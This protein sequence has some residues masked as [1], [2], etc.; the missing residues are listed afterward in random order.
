MSE[1][2]PIETQE[3]FDEAIKSRIDR[4]TKTVTAEI[5]KKYEGYLSPEEV[6]NSTQQYTDQIAQLT[7]SLKGKDKE[8]ADLSAANK[9]NV[10]STA[11]MKIAY[12]LGIPFELSERL[13]GETEDEIR[14][15]AEKI[16]KY[17][18]SNKS[19]PMF[20]AEKGGTNPVQQGLMNALSSLKNT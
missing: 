8:I 2:T 15:D 18:R 17:I 5:T 11:K 6:Q 13:S 1:F 4:N 16:A 10:N 14:A 3:A 7:E 20:N 12:E 9:A 19:A